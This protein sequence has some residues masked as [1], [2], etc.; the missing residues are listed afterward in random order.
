MK[1]CERSSPGD[2]KGCEGRGGGGAEIPLQ[3]GVQA[4]V[5]KAAP[6]QLNEVQGEADIH[7]QYLQDPTLDQPV[8][9]GLYPTERTILEQVL[10]NCSLSVMRKKSHRHSGRS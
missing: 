5:R 4:V 10:K 7:L 2:T 9:V 8:S 6:L 1:M 3:S